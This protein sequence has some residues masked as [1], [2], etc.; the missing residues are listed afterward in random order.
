MEARKQLVP[1]VYA[2]A[3]FGLIVVLEAVIEALDDGGTQESCG[4]S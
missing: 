1:V 4:A 2:L 3:L